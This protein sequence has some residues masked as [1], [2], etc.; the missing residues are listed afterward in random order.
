MSRKHSACW[1]RLL[2]TRIPPSGD[3]SYI[4][5]TRNN[6]HLSTRRQQ[7]ELASADVQREILEGE[8]KTRQP[9][10]NQKLRSIG[11][12]GLRASG[13]K[14]LQINV[15]EP[16][17]R[18][19]TAWR[20]DSATD[21]SKSM[22]RE[23]AEQIIDVLENHDIPT[24]DICGVA[25][26]LNP[27]FRWLVKQAHMLGRHVIDRCNLTVLMDN[28][29]KD[30]PGFLA[31]HDVEVVA[32]LPYS[33]EVDRDSQHSDKALKRF[34]DALRRLNRLGYGYPGLGRKLTLVYHPAGI[35]LPPSQH[36][37]EATYRDELSSRYDIIFSELHVVTHRPISRFLDNLL[38]N[39]QLD[40]YMQM[41]I[42]SFSPLAAENVMCRS[43]LAVDWRGYLFD[44]DFNQKLN[45]VLS[46]ELPQHISQFDAEKL[47]DRVIQTGRHC[48]GCTAGCGSAVV[49]LSTQDAS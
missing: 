4:P 3:G 26:E 32:S 30:L 17:N 20:M 33:M 38:R 2:E 28:D 18:T 42:D 8:A 19:G 37:L 15:G 40:E 1:L 41:L 49:K 46:S 21:R 5:N 29:S 39:D 36:E 27:N 48:F 43:M 13:I 10:F 45:M 34:I 11:L 25:P 7:N 23:T 9:Y 44:C 6:M 24:L 16:S 31:K 14:V 22:S 12:S 47:G 35:T